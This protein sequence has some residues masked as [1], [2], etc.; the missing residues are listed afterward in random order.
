MKIHFLGTGDGSQRVKKSDDV[1]DIRRSSSILI[2]DMLLV[3]PG[4]DIF[5]F[6]KDFGYSG[7]YDETEG[8]LCTNKNKGNYSK[9]SALRLGAKEV[10]TKFFKPVETQFFNIT[11]LPANHP[12][13]KS[14]K[15]FIIE[16]K[17]DGRRIF[18][19][20]DG[21][22]LLSQ[23]AQV[24]DTMRF[25]VMIFEATLCEREGDIEIFEHNNLNAVKELSKVFSKKADKI[26]VSH[27]GSNSSM[28]HGEIADMTAEWNVGV[29]YDDLKIEI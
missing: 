7:L 10:K 14:P 13:A 25:D 21:A 4:P 17:T 22:M 19:G 3:D 9:I 18:Y 2:D 20:G 12:S 27:I 24:L 6:E 11:A 1:R 8:Y 29:A 16:S 15:C 23:T 26:F 5:K 28:T